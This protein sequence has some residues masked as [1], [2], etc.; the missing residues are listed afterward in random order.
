MKIEG[1]FLG[2]LFDEIRKEPFRRKIVIA[3]S[4][5]EGQSWLMRI[6]RELGPVMNVEVH[7]VQSFVRS[8]VEFSLYKQGLTLIGEQRSFWIIHYVMEQMAS[9]RDSYIS[10]DQVKPGIAMHVHKAIMDLRR[11]GVRAEELRDNHFLSQQKGCYVRK[12]LSAY[13]GFLKQRNWTDFPGL[14]PY[15]PAQLPDNVELILPDP[16]PLPLVSARMLERLSNSRMTRIKTDASFTD[17]NSAL[18]FGEVQFYHATGKLAEVREAF[19]RIIQGRIPLDE[20]EMIVPD[21]EYAVAISTMCAS[22]D[23]SC[24]FA[25]G[26]PVITSGMGR[27]AHFLLN[28]LESGYQVRLLVSMLQQQLITL[29]DRD[30]G[31]SNVDC[32][33]TLEKSGIGWGKERYIKLLGAEYVRSQEDSDERP[34]EQERTEHL[35]REEEI[36]AYLANLLGDLFPDEA[37]LCSPA[38]IWGWLVKILDRFGVCRVE[39]DA[40]VRQE[41]KDMGKELQECP[42]PDSMPIQQGFLY[43]REMLQ[44]LRVGVQPLPKP[45]SL[46]VSSLVN[47]G[48][49]GRKHSFL[50]GMDERL[51]SG[52]IRQNPML[53]DEE[54]RRIGPELQ[55]AVQRQRERQRHRD[56]R[57]GMMSGELTLSFSSY[58]LAE[59]TT[60]SPAFQL[61]QVFRKATGEPNADY[62]T[63]HHSLGE[64]VGYLDVEKSSSAE[65]NKLPLDGA[66]FG[67]I[68]SHASLQRDRQA[69]IESVYPVLHRGRTA[70]EARGCTQVTEHD[71]YIA[72]EEWTAYWRGLSERTLS[73]SQLE[74]Y[75]ECPMRYF[76][77]YVLGIRVKDQVTFDR[78]SWLKPNERGS[79]LHEVYRRYMT[80]VCASHVM[81]ITHDYTLLLRI[82]EA[83]IH[84]YAERIPA[85]SPHVFEKERQAMLRDVEV[86]FRMEVQGKTTPRFF[87]QELIVDGQPLRLELEDGMTI[88]LRGIVDR[89]DQVAPHQYR[90][91]DYKTGSP[92]PYKENGVFVGGTQLQHALYAW[93]TELWM[94]QTG[95]DSDAKVIEAAY[96]FPS[97]R[98]QGQVIARSQSERHRVTEVIRRI[99]SSMEQGVFIPASGTGACRYCD[100]AAVCGDHAEMMVHKREDEVN[101]ELLLTLLEVENLE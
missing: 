17:V 9:E 88:S 64:P 2:R 16:M 27:A 93:G 59:G 1:T 85:P 40:I 95:L 28:W 36:K 101:T 22:L 32:I 55:T 21:E 10:M 41:M 29:S 97:E 70:L 43:V 81:P 8:Q 87:E 78:T 23:L 34:V 45:G 75:A 18:P 20:V 68:H 72:G 53:L 49:S 56:G 11:A 42:V 31:I 63:L 65:P 83:T 33:R 96:V 51:W 99:L 37:A 67:H 24:S 86:F 14:L 74:K 58:D 89:I 7:T 82:A 39:E 46:Y 15:L 66:V 50:L 62:E 91:I 60:I 13:E 26:L 71:G 38:S 76:F 54:C 12:V 19:R 100:Y 77:Q 47:G 35:Q 25:N 98:G 57:L 44:E 73:A 61:L 48:I 90:I 84:A 3:P 92:R 79:L 69:V 6:C 30:Q 4:Y 94:Q 80:E 5:M 52:N